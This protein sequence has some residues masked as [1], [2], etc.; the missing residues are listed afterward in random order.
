MTDTLTNMRCCA[1]LGD[2]P[3]PAPAPTEIGAELVETASQA[4]GNSYQFL[5][6]FDADIGGGGGE[7]GQSLAAE[8]PDERNSVELPQCCAELGDL[9]EPA[10][11]P[12][13]TEEE[14]VEKVGQPTFR[15][16]PIRATRKTSSFRYCHLSHSV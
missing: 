3:E 10:P 8:V 4:A 6:V 11:A 12:A 9:P 13:E 1:E 16:R 7:A 15:R 5:Q 2:L 14:L